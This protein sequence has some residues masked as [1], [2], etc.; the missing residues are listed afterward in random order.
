MY[1]FAEKS[2]GIWSWQNN[3]V[4]LIIRGA[5]Q[6]GKT[7]TVIEFAKSRFKHLLKVNFE[8]D[9][10]YKIFFQKNYDVK[11]FLEALAFKTGIEPVAGETL[12]F[13]DEIQQCP[14]AIN[15]LRYFYE[16]YPGLHVIAAGSL[17]DFAL[18]QKDIR[19]P[20]GRVEY[21]HMYPMSFKEFLLAQKKEQY[22]SYIE[23]I[24]LHEKP[25]PVIHEQLLLE[26]KKYFLIGGMPEAVSKY[27]SGD[28]TY[29]DVSKVHQKLLQ[30]YIQDFAR[31]PK[32]SYHDDVEAVFNFV[33]ENLG[34][35]FMYSR[36]YPE[37]KTRNI[38][39][40]VDLLLKAALLTK[41]Q[42]TSAHLP[43]AAGASS[44][45]FKA[46]FLDIGL[47][48]ARLGYDINF[49][50]NQDV[51]S[52]ANGGLAEQYVGQELLASESSYKPSE[53]FYWQ[54]ENPS[55]SAE[56]D[57]LRAIGTRVLP[58]EVKFGSATH[59]KS[60]RIFME[61]YAVPLGLRVSQAELS[62]QEDLLSLP[63][64]LV[65]EVERLSQL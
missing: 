12:I 58:I 46:L 30:G 21:L 26:I 34:K 55:S 62:S 40:A 41:V 6:V 32:H 50:A 16:Q 9:T 31:Y 15:A 61:E 57:Y 19:V 17:L 38:K 65:S 51:F 23:N 18:D 49:L 27:I 7:Y 22:V 45:I 56:I 37:A 33:P 8:I 35:K 63:F 10:S 28:F 24:S 11:S 5:R 43:L 13:L 2:L 48:S 54:R 1:R 64:Y 52:T 59:L 20:V 4:P 44:K 53:L 42:A 47:V 14:E 60:L 39:I 36:V 29:I 25:N 3:P